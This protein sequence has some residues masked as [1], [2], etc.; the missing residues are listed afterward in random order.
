MKYIIEILF[1]LFTAL[2]GLVAYCSYVYELKPKESLNKLRD[3]KFIVVLEVL[4]SIFVLIVLNVLF[5]EDVSNYFKMQCLLSILIPISIIDRN[6]HIIPNK[7]LIVLLIERV[8]CVFLD[9]MV[10]MQDVGW[11]SLG[12]LVTAAIIYVLFLAM[13]LITR[14]GIGGGDVKLFALIGLFLNAYGAMQCLL[15]SFIVS[16]VVSVYLLIS[17]KKNRKDELPFGPMLL[18]G[19]LIKI[20][21]MGA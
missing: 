3:E 14:N 20:V 15:Y 18:A 6:K 16:F 12:C 5:K 19:L 21:L 13:Q 7:L 8:V 11:Y 1:S 10:G 4:A 9:L 2:I 17:K